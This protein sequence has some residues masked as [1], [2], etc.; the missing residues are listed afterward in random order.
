MFT[1]RGIVP[2]V[3]TPFDHDRNIDFGSLERLMVRSIDDGITGCIL[4]AVASEVSK[5]SVEER[6]DLVRAVSE[7]AAGRIEVI[8][9]VSSEDARESQ[10]LIEHSLSLGVKTVLCQV[11]QS[12]DGDETAIRTHFTRVAEA[13]A[14]VLI[15]QDLAWTGWGLRAGFVGELFDEIESFEAIKVEVIPAGAKYS[16]VLEA[17]QGRIHVSCGWGLGQMIEALDRGVQ[18]FTTTAINLPFVRIF[19]LY[20]MGQRDNAMELF[21]R[22]APLLVWGQQHIDI[23]IQFLKQY[24]VEVGIFATDVVREPIQAYD[25]V[26]RAYGA[27]LIDGV[28]ALEDELRRGTVAGRA[29][30][31]S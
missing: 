8:A 7:I 17:T 2:I 12:L 22:M 5:L 21:D 29:G 11:P 9:G 14:P 27:H 30:S 26:H 16:A 31:A 24:C 23:S 13:G 1:L 3:N 19:D 15:I 25:Q 10:T 4:P 20:E 6:K 28:L 18:V